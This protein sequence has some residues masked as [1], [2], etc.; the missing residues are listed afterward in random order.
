MKDIKR[1]IK[2]KIINSDVTADVSSLKN[3]INKIFRRKILNDLLVRGILA[4]SRALNCYRIDGKKILDRKCKDWDFIL[5]ESQLIEFF[6]D[7]KIYEYEIGRSEYY[8]DKTL[9]TFYGDY[10]SSD[11]DIL[12]CKI[13]IFV[14]NSQNYKEIDGFK[15]S[16]INEIIDSKISISENMN[17]STDIR[18]KHRKDINNIFL[19]I[20]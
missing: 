9:M 2:L 1:D 8:L 20:Y 14:K 15:I 6:R 13:N 7:N 4:G 16:I 5:S 17:L 19:N 10:G 12:P 3:P 11:L 18:Y